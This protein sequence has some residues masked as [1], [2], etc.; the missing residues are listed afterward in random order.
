MLKCFS[1]LHGL[2]GYTNYI[3]S[4]SSITFKGKAMQYDQRRVTQTNL[5]SH[6]ANFNNV[7]RTMCVH[8]ASCACACKC[9]LHVHARV[10]AHIHMLVSLERWVTWK[11]INVVYVKSAECWQRSF[12]VW[13][14]DLNSPRRS[15]LHTRACM[16]V[17]TF[18]CVRA[19]LCTHAVYF[20]AMLANENRWGCSYFNA[21]GE[22]LWP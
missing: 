6:C 17:H 20:I 5:F 16:Y 15:L 22:I 2:V 12:W 18:V 4:R 21:R 1:G 10:H 3:E 11:Y 8:G 7:E 19:C 14:D 13:L 9:C